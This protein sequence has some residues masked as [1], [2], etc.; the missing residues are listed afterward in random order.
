M[1]SVIWSSLILD[2]ELACLDLLLED[3]FDLKKYSYIYVNPRKGF[4]LLM[5]LFVLVERKGEER[6][7]RNGVI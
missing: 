5:A 3:M 2:D 4:L 7:R 6:R 1:R